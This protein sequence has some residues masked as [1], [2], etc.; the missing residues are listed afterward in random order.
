[1]IRSW[2][3]AGKELLQTRRD[4]LAA[5]FSI[6]LPM[7]FTVFLGLLFTGFGDPTALPLGVAD[8][9]GSP[10]ARELVDRLQAESALDVRPMSAEALEEAVQDQ[11]VAAGLIIPRGYGT[12]VEAGEPAALQFVRIETSSGAQS[13]YQAV[14]GAVARMNA[15]RL[16][17][18]TAAEQVGS[19]L[20]IPADEE[21]RTAAQ[22]RAAA[23]LATPAIITMLTDSRTMASDQLTSF[24]QAST[25]ALVN[26]VLFGL[27]T[28]TTG[29]AWERRQGTP[30]SSE[31]NARGGTA[32]RER[33]DDGHG[34]PELHAATASWSSWVSS[35][36]E[37]TTSTVLP[38]SFL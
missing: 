33:Q 25:G 34:P 21:L 6:V 28:V 13:V 8:A 31:H 35:P 7:I 3:I 26:W 36:S 23:L 9:D 16:A 11:D 22:D 12:A 24:D 18:A 32:D 19:A 15:E 27:L 30:S 10:A 37:W 20:G 14:Q 1:M 17:A 5:L 2:H 4:K 38:P 29:L